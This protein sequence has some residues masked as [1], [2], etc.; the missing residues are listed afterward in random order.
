MALEAR[1]EQTRRPTEGP[2]A[3]GRHPPMP[4]STALAP[5]ESPIP[6]AGKEPMMT[7]KR[8]IRRFDA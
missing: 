6:A 3:I 4:S 2:G 1:T 8:A 7:E 5:R